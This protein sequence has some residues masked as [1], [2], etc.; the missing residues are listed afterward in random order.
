MDDDDEGRTF[1]F[2]RRGVISV[3]ELVALFREA[4]GREPTPKE[5]EDLQHVLDEAG[6]HGASLRIH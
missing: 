5:L 1:L 6:N 4:S 2:L 3:N